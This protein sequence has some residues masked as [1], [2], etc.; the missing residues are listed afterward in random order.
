MV[1]LDK[2]KYDFLKSDK[3]TIIIEKYGTYRL[4]IKN[5]PRQLFL[6][7]YK[8]VFTVNSTSYQIYFHLGIPKIANQDGK[9]IQIDFLRILNI[10]N[11]STEILID[12][13]NFNNSYSYNLKVSNDV[14]YIKLN[15]KPSEDYEAIKADLVALQTSIK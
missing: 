12:N 8:N 3:S 15:E 5:N 2:K 11:E 14:V 9:N 7:V 4:S 13:N 1:T 6:S 10:E